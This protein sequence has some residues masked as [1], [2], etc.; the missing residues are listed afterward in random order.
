MVAARCVAV[1]VSVASVLPA[2]ATGAG[3][4]HVDDVEHDADEEDDERDEEHLHVVTF[5]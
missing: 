1:L 5:Q 4:H 3:G 2:S